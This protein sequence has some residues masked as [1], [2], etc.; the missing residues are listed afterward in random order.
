MVW[1][2]ILIAAAALKTPTNNVYNAQG[3]HLTVYT[4]KSI[5]TYECEREREKEREVEKA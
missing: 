3:V 4:C 2:S 1:G 5:Y